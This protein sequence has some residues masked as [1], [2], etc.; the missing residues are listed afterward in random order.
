MQR[1]DAEW[2]PRV[3]DLMYVIAVAEAAQRPDAHVSAA[4][5]PGLL[6]RDDPHHPRSFVDV[7]DVAVLAGDR[8]L[9]DKSPA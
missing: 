3:G 1:A 4:P 2:P 9:T 8:E 6:D 5:A 7:A